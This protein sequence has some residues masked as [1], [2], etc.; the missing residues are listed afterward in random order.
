MVSRMG[1]S[2]AWRHSRGVAEMEAGIAG[3]VSVGGAQRQAFTAA[4]LGKGYGKLGRIDQAIAM[5]DDQR[6][7]IERSGERLDEA[8]LYRVKGE[9]LYA[10]DGARSSERESCLR[11]AIE[12]AQRPDRDGGNCA[13]LP[14]S[15]GC[16]RTKAVAIRRARCSPTSTADSPRA[17]K[18]PT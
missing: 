15:R 5:L 6:V 8:E 7:R 18:P 12:I 14:A 17:S 1:T 11:Q 4:M 16:S 9:L 13:R 2:R 3:F 10:R